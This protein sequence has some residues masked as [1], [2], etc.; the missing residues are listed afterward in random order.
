MYHQK[1]YFGAPGTGKSHK[2][3]EVD[4][5]GIPNQQ[6]FRTVVHPEYSYSD[7][8][9]QLLPEDD[10]SGGVIFKFNQ[11]PFTE[12]LFKAF[13]DNNKQVF[14]IIEEMSRGNV[15]AIFGDIFQLLDRNERFES[16]YPIRNKDIASQLPHNVNNEIILPSNLNIIGTV[17][18]SDQSVFPM[19]TA[20]K[21]RFEWEYVS[22]DPVEADSSTV[23]PNNDYKNNPYIKL[24]L[25]EPTSKSIV[26]QKIEWVKLYQILNSYITD[27]AEGL[28]KTEDQQIGHFFIKFPD[29]LIT[30]SQSTDNNTRDNAFKEISEIIKNKLIMYLWQDIQGG[31]TG[32]VQ[33]TLFKEDISS[34]QD[35]YNKYSSEPLWVETLNSKIYA[36]SEPI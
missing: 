28:G 8:V 30:D 7:F 15:S 5:N 32:Y 31:N 10:G 2:I 36:K 33:K 9:G 14:L 21:R 6:I 20:F 11:G 13:D 24:P 27:K 4:L 35:I 26:E 19:D 22:I 23:A 3:D 1:I 34:Y 17:N 16:K 18:L 29:E 25:Y 12:S